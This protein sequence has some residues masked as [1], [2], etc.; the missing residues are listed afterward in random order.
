LA[1]AIPRAGATHPT[2]RQHRDSKAKGKSIKAKVKILMS[3]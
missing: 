3:S 1:A 2:P